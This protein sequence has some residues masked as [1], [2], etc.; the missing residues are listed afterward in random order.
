MPIHKPPVDVVQEQSS[1]ED[2][3]GMQKPLK[4]SGMWGRGPCMRKTMLGKTEEFADGF[5]LCSPGRWPPQMRRSAQDA[6]Q[7]GFMEQIGV[8]L[9]KIL[10]NCMNVRDL[11][12]RFAAG[13]I[14]SC[15]FSKETIEHGRE[16][17]FAALE[18]AGT[19][20][21]VREAACGQPF[22]LAAMEELLRISGDPDWRAYYSSSVSFAKGVRLGCGTKTPRVPAVFDRKVRWRQYG[23]DAAHDLTTERENYISAASHS[24]EVQAQFVAEAE[25]GAMMEVT[26]EAAIA[27]YGER[28]AVASLGAIEKKDGTYRVVH[29]G[30]HG[31]GVNSAIRIRD[32]ARSPSAGELQQ[33]MRGMPGIFF[34]LTGDVKRAHRLVKVAEEDWGLQACRTNANGPGQF[35]LNLVGTFGVSSAAYHWARLMAGLGRLGYYA[36]GKAGVQQLVYVDGS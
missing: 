7:L 9:H 29:D 18:D 12:M 17:I 28:L 1:D 19:K 3:D 6:P 13:K 32:Q 4:G 15:P 36:L 22:Y 23:D 33:A 10:E 30:T 5:G 21:P 25:L 34:A 16:L 8:E 31:V 20:L 14:C 26:C 35:W 11:A 2:E 27:K 24:K